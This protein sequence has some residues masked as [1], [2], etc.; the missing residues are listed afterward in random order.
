MVPPK[1]ATYNEVPVTPEQVWLLFILVE[2]GGYLCL[3]SL[4]EFTL[5]TCKDMINQ[6]VRPLW[7][8]MKHHDLS[9]MF[10]FS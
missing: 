4:V 9:S 1:P 2:C 10:V 5:G 3:K 7:N 6:G 8:R